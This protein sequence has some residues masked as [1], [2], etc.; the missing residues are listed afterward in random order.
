M[1][2]NLTALLMSQTLTTRNQNFNVCHF[3][4]TS[5]ERRNIL[6][7][8]QILCWNW[9]HSSVFIVQLAE[10]MIFKIINYDDLF[11]PSLAGFS[12]GSNWSFSIL[13]LLGACT[14]CRCNQ[15]HSPWKMAVFLMCLF[16]DD[17]LGL[18]G[19][20]YEKL[21]WSQQWGLRNFLKNIERNRTDACGLI[22]LFLG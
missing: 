16:F 3:S 13:G 4:W 21:N 18:R 7:F 19:G 5:F 22:I 1:F 9:T 12:V 6:P 8:L 11:F 10:Y 14:V 20:A 17:E 2:F 15:R